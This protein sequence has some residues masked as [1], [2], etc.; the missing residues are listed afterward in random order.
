MI[1]QLHRSVCE[2]NSLR[3]SVHYHGCHD[4]AVASLCM[5][6]QYLR[7]KVELQGCHDRMVASLCMCHQLSEVYLTVSGVS[8]S[9]GGIALYV[10]SI[11]SGRR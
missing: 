5:L 4:S 2:T 6:H 10:V 9:C 7:S 8:E 11:L 3:S 1:V